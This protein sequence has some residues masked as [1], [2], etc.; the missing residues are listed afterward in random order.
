MTIQITASFSAHTSRTSDHDSLSSLH[1]GLKGT[2]HLSSTSPSLRAQAHAFTSHK[3]NEQQLQPTKVIPNTSPSVLYGQSARATS[4]SGAFVMSAP[5]I[6]L[7]N[8]T[9]HLRISFKV[10]HPTTYPLDHVLHEHY[11]SDI[12]ALSP[13]T[14]YL[15]FYLPRHITPSPVT[16][17]WCSYGSD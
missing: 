3:T 4:S 7:P 16:S 15:T 2:A 8:E 1:S 10:C 13:L 11:S 14:I 5:I 12:I 6:L 17:T 9:R